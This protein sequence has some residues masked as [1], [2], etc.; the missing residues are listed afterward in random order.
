[1]SQSDLVRVAALAPSTVSGIVAQ[2]RAEGMLAEWNGDARVAPG[3]KG[4]RPGTIW[5]LQS[6]VGVVA[7]I[8]FGRKHVRVALADLA[9]NILA[10]KSAPL[11]PDA[12]ASAHIAR[13]SA[14]L[15]EVLPEVGLKKDAVLNVGVGIP[16]PLHPANRQLVNSSILPGWAG[17]EV[18]DAVGAALSL[19][20]HVANDADL[21]ALS[22]WMWGSARGRKDVVYL[23]ASSGIGAGL[24]LGGIPY[25]GAGGTAGEIGHVPVDPQGQACRCGNTGCLETVAGT[26]S[27]L[28]GLKHLDSKLTVDRLI[29]RAKAGE[30]AYVGALALA[31]HAIGIALGMLCNLINPERIVVGGELAAAGPLL[32]VPM[33]TALRQAA[34]DSAVD[35][36]TVV[37]SE[38]QGRAE[39]LG[40]VA[41]ALRTAVPSRTQR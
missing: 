21:G 32:L 9:H 28:E 2:L 19:P 22:E 37:E 31:G 5:A 10:V 33:R 6:S 14:L 17:V 36:L 16:G 38:L 26:G 20:V 11:V 7:G 23:K 24:I 29:Q 30:P 34:L 3:P 40:A 13:A 1:M 27:L 4:G 39:V 25:G 15:D 41:L 12:P 8:D 35:D 18:S